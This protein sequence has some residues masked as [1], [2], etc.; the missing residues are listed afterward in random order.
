MTT[1]LVTKVKL[2]I[3][4]IARGLSPADREFQR[5]WPAVDGVEGWLLPNEGA[6]L[7]HAARSLP[8]AANIVEVGSFKGRSTCCLALG[9]KRTQRRVFAVDT[10][11]GGPDLPKAELLPDFLR[12][13]EVTGLSRFVEPR[14]GLSTEVSSKWDKPIHLLF[15][16]GS[17]SYEDVL[18]DFNGFYPYVVPGGIVAFHDVC[19]AWPGVLR[20]WNKIE[21]QLTKTGHCGA[22][23]YGRKLNRP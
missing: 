2:K 23:G 18:A 16:D 19:E 22:L 7:F 21:L 10:F 1:P 5:I 20:A 3:K 17:H 9:C 8:K 12:N 11:D 14:V 15:I 6:W 13:L 4:K